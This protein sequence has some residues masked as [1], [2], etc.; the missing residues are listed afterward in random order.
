[1][2]TDTH[3]SIIDNKWLYI[4]IFRVPGSPFE[5]SKFSEEI[6]GQIFS[7]RTAYTLVST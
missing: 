1:M 5:W 6:H 3:Y 2:Q 7:K 4:K